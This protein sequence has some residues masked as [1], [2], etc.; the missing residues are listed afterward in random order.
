MSREQSPDI[1]ME[2]EPRSPTS[3]S[4]QSEDHTRDGAASQKSRDTNTAAN[5]EGI[6]HTNLS[7]REGPRNGM[8]ASR[9]GSRV[10][11]QSN[12]IDASQPRA[13]STN[14]NGAAKPI[15]M[16]PH[17][18]L[19]GSQSRLSAA[20][21]TGG[22]STSQTRTSGVVARAS[23]SSATT[24]APVAAGA[25]RPPS[26]PVARPTAPV[27]HTPSASMPRPTVLSASTRRTSGS[28][29]CKA[30]M[31]QVST[32]APDYTAYPSD[33]SKYLK[34][35]IRRREEAMMLKLLPTAQ[36]MSQTVLQAQTAYELIAH[37]EAIEFVHISHKR[38]EA[39]MKAKEANSAKVLKEKVE[40]QKRQHR[41]EIAQQKN[42]V[43]AA[44]KQTEA[45]I[46]EKL[47]ALVSLQPKL[48]I[49]PAV[50]AQLQDPSSDCRLLGALLVEER[51]LQKALK[52]DARYKSKT[53]GMDGGA[54]PY[55]WKDCVCASF[56]ASALMR[57]EP[58]RAS[59]VDVPFATKTAADKKVV[60]VKDGAGEVVAWAHTRTGPD[61]SALAEAYLKA[62][63]EAPEL[64]ASAYRGVLWP[65]ED[66]AEVA[67]K[68]RA[69]KSP[70]ADILPEVITILSCGEMT[71]HELSKKDVAALGEA[72]S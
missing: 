29:S 60:V 59:I 47:K 70:I 51:Q 49:V 45:D 15:P 20:S 16:V 65:K 22:A 44:A 11:S 18:L 19:S 54:E 68:A 8:G 43:A 1:M 50:M 35:V 10:I 67:R 25:G 23:T 69:V 56:N 33:I 61:P 9:N 7:T 52:G 27:A 5:C 39:E 71:S 34:D 6:A 12:S 40:E 72:A 14:S 62:K 55:W 31:P 28:A 30:F 36:L 57:Q 13:V 2:S 3:S 32:A 17:L 38:R 66:A 4:S 58:H 53:T 46:R 24:A 21:T 42:E 64:P 37:Q 63:L 26:A 41:E 48:N